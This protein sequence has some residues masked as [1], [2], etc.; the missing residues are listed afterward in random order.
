MC[1]TVCREYCSKGAAA[2]TYEIYRDLAAA[3]G[4]AKSNRSR[5][6]RTMAR[7]GL[8]RLEKGEGR[9]LEPVVTFDK[10]ELRLAP[11]A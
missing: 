7:Y 9:K 6:L 4:R 10:V 5:T 1:R 8:V 2:R 11:A 3:S